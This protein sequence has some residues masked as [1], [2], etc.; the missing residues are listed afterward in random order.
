MAWLN[1]INYRQ[2]NHSQSRMSHPSVS[3]DESPLSP[4][5]SKIFKTKPKEPLLDGLD[6]MFDFISTEDP[7]KL[8]QN[9]NL[10]DEGMTSQL[11]E[12]EW[13]DSKKEVIIKVADMTKSVNLN[14]LIQYRISDALVQ[15]N[16]FSDLEPH[17]YQSDYTCAFMNGPDLMLVFDKSP[18]VTLLEYCKHTKRDE[19]EISRILAKILHIFVILHT[20]EVVHPHQR[21][22]SIYYDEH[23]KRIE[24][25][26]FG[27]LGQ[28]FPQ[29]IQHHER[30]GCPFWCSPEEIRE[31][32]YNTK[33][34]IWGLGIVLIEMIEGIPPHF[35]IHP[36]RAIF[37][38]ASRDPPTLKIP[39][40]YSFELNEFLALC[41]QK[42]PEKRPTAETLLEHR[43]IIQF[44]IKGQNIRRMHFVDDVF[45]KFASF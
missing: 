30:M 41:L 16:E 7:T 4:V 39:E 37:Y 42:D 35:D 32:G 20:R 26:H 21:A 12:A 38:I 8:F 25:A 31:R 11:Y 5:T 40:N 24:F 18:R 34:D 10:L 15:W 13:I 2:T 14:S 23:L 45:F 27:T 3:D 19:R 28:L 36:M 22:E 33:R 9:V 29:D 44:D 43:F 6:M 17:V 1:T